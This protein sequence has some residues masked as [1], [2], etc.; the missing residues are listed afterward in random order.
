MSKFNYNLRWVKKECLQKRIAD[1]SKVST[2]NIFQYYF[3][4]IFYIFNLIQTLK[5]KLNAKKYDT[6]NT[7]SLSSIAG[8]SLT[9]KKY[10]V[11]KVIS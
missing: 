2:F 8:S 5:R 4:I 3:S 1:R 7:D 6:N 11:I 10:R 9:A